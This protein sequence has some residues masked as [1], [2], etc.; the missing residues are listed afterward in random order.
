MGRIRV[1]TDNLRSYANT[2]TG[3]IG[4]YDS[5]ITRME[6]LNQ[7]IHAT[8]K[9]EAQLRFSE[10]MDQ[11]IRQTRELSEILSQFRDYAQQ[12]ADKFET[13]DA[14]CASRIRSSF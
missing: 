8:W 13:V 3:R 9:G 12:T 4:E 1:N 2:L 14:E 11:Y 10:M 5:L 6:A 7:N